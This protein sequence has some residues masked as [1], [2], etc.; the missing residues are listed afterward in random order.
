MEREHKV[1]TEA[2]R[3]AV[4]GISDNPERDS[5]RIALML[6]RNNYEVVGVHPKLKDVEGIPVYQSI[7]EIPGDVDIIDIFINSERLPSIIPS[8]INKK[9]KVMWLQLGV[10]ND[11]AV[12]QVESVGIEVIQD[13][14]IAV[15][16]NRLK[17]MQN[18]EV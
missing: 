2:K 18:Q 17:A 15:E 9:P 5:G 1:L 3:I 7:D 12:K 6:K 4:V 14:C 13:K 8:L 11:E 10:H 16:Y